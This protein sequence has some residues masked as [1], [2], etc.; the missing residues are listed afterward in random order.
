MVR[1]NNNQRHITNYIVKRMCRCWMWFVLG[2]ERVFDTVGCCSHILS[3]DYLLRWPVLL[4]QR[5]WAVKSRVYNSCCGWLRTVERQQCFS[6]FSASKLP[7]LPLLFWFW[8]WFIVYLRLNKAN[9]G[10]MLGRVDCQGSI[11]FRFKFE[12][13]ER[14]E[15]DEVNESWTEGTNF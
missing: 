10:S 8:F 11:L 1:Y 7:N 3:G 6:L 12:W 15:I 2:L 9:D 5:E 4:G 14:I 13:N